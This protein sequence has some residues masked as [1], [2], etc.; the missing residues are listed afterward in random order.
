MTCKYEVCIK[1]VTSSFF[2]RWE[3]LD[4]GVD[5]TKMTISFILDRFAG[6]RALHQG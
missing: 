4:L 6:T 1:V 5:Y 3:A 2:V